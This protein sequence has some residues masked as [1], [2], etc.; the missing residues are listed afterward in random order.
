MRKF[1]SKRGIYLLLLGVVTLTV[2]LPTTLDNSYLA[3]QFG[4]STYAS[5]KII[6]IAA[7]A[8][9][10]WAVIAVV[11]GSAGWGTVILAAAK[12]LIKR[13]GRAAAASW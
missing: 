4:I 6:D 12:A 13:Y 9:S 11:G 7:G 1:I 2:L 10:V 8:G 5:K 3:A